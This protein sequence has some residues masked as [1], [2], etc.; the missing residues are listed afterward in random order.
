MSRGKYLSLEEAQKSGKLKQ[1]A[2]EHPSKGD[3][4]AFDELKKVDGPKFRIEFGRESISRLSESYGDMSE[5]EI[6]TFFNDQDLLEIAI[7]EGDSAA[8]L[9][10]EYETWVKIYFSKT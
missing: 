8:L 1:F 3:K 10:L 5:G 9:G 7:C 2:K 4:R 6:V